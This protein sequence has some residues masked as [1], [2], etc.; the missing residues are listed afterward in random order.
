MKAT[1]ERVQRAELAGQMRAMINASEKSGRDFTS[2]E[3]EK[4][5]RLISAYDAVDAKIKRLEAEGAQLDE[6]PIASAHVASL[7]TSADEVRANLMRGG[8]LNSAGVLRSA[9]KWNRRPDYAE[10]EDHDH[11]AAFSAYIRGGAAGLNDDQRAVLNKRWVPNAAG[12]LSPMNTMSTGTGSQGGFVVPTGFSGMLEEAM[13]W[14][15]GIEDS[16]DVFTTETGNPWPF[17]LAA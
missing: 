5:D 14:F 13:K 1:R 17:L 15:G 2:A 12:I 4:Y 3:R 6:Y 8:V 16:V 7:G 10:G 11:S 9:T